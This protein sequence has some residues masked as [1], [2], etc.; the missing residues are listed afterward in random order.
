MEIFGE[1]DR[2]GGGKTAP[3]SSTYPAYYFKEHV[4]Q[5]EEET[6]RLRRSIEDGTVDAK[7]LPA[8]KEEY[9]LNKEKLDKVNASAPKLSSND[10]DKLDRFIKE[11]GDQVSDLMPTHTDM[12]RGTASPQDEVRL[13]H[14]EGCVS[15]GGHKQLFADMGIT[16]RKNG[17]VTRNEA[18]KAWKIA[19]SLRGRPTNTELL[20]KD[21]V[22]HSYKHER[23]LE[24]MKR[25]EG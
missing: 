7:Y 23:S 11:I 8:V 1:V 10:K 25:D 13:M 16:P 21:R 6:G 17:K 3:T 4:E 18:A 19:S 2:K 12:Q 24:E 22:G 15:T 14:K 20:R 9:R 5:L